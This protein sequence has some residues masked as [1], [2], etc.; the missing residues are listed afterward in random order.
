MSMKNRV[1]RLTTALTVAGLISAQIPMSGGTALAANK[2]CNRGGRFLGTSLTNEQVFSGVTLGILGYSLLKSLRDRGRVATPVP[3]GG[4]T[5]GGGT[6]PVV[7]MDDCD[8]AKSVGNFTESLYD[9]LGAGSGDVKFSALK[10]LIDDAG[11][12]SV[13]KDPN[14]GPFTVFAP[15]D[16]SLSG[17]PASA[18]SALRA[19]KLKLAEV[20]STHVIIGRYSYLDL[21]RMSD[22]N[23]LTLSGKTVKV[24]HKNGKIYIDNMLVSPLDFKGTAGYAH[25]LGGIIN[26]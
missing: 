14:Q 5:V 11:I 4:G 8:K 22:K 25:P 26:K 12:A 18:I 23:L 19:N 13:L 24:T 20:V 2:K 10:G 15:S 1:I 6:P 9:L 3:S 7:A 17:V 21:C 16:S